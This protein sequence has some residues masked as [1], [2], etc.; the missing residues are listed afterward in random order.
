MQM[1]MKSG[2]PW[3]IWG[4]TLRVGCTQIWSV[5]YIFL[6][7]SYPDLGRSVWR[8]TCVRFFGLEW[9]GQSY[10]SWLLINVSKYFWFW[11]WICWGIRLFV[12][13]AYSHFSAYTASFHIFSV[14]EQ[15]YSAFSQYTNRFIP[16]IQRICTANSIQKFTLILWILPYM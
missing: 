8:S 9:F 15:I 1:K 2:F 16:C 6:P 12:H 3:R 4:K 5:F 11:F 10:P 14:Q 7:V 13:F